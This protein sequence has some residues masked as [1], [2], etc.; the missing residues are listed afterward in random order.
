MLWTTLVWAWGLDWVFFP[1]VLLQT[2]L[3]YQICIPWPFFFQDQGFFGG[4]SRNSHVLDL[5]Q[6]SQMWLV[7]VESVLYVS[8]C[9]SKPQAQVEPT[10]TIFAGSLW[11]TLT[12]KG[13]RCL[14]VHVP[15]CMNIWLLV[16]QSSKRSEDRLRCMPPTTRE[17][18]SLWHGLFFACKYFGVNCRLV[19]LDV[20]AFQGCRILFRSQQGLSWESVVALDCRI[21]KVTAKWRRDCRWQWVKS[22]SCSGWK[23]SIVLLH[24]YFRANLR[25]QSN[26]NE[27]ATKLQPNC[28]QSAIKL[29][30]QSKCNQTAAKVQSNSKCSQSAIKLQSNCSQGAIKVQSKWT[31]I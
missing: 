15:T 24:G 12:M 18:V 10:S 5:L 31:V 13:Q 3:I 19:P 28:S 26:Y 7:Y 17:A 20:S 23:K 25:V 22:H 8:G 29:K 2:Q 11:H 6:S 4:G 30:V 16:R 9:F 14:R 27:S 21:G 1:T